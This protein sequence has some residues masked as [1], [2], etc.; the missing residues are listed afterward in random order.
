MRF[1]AGCWM[2]L[3]T[4]ALATCCAAQENAEVFTIAVYDGTHMRRGILD[5][6]E[7]T[8]EN[9]LRRAGIKTSW[10]NCSGWQGAVPAEC[11]RPSGE[12]FLVIRITAKRDHRAGYEEAM[13]EA[14]FNATGKSGYCRIFRN[15]L[16]EVASASHVDAGNL[17][18]SSMAHEVGHVLKS[19]H[20]HSA[21][22]LMSAHWF[23]PEITAAGRGALYFGSDDV[24][25]LGEG[26]RR[27]GEILARNPRVK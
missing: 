25:K 19:D 5:R 4:V 13:G 22:G 3:G 14:L 9:L 15:Q 12:G 7:R 6:G 1:L 20:G 26:S 11:S 17:L 18:G 8:A 24:E 16:D 23:S 2:A 21:A 27:G 10:L